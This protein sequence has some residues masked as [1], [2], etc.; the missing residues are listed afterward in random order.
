[1][2]TQFIMD[3]VKSQKAKFIIFPNPLNLLNDPTI[4]VK[5]GS[6]FYLKIFII[7]KLV[8][9]PRSLVFRC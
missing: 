8:E 7:C 3:I 2:F 9:I 4:R 6:T 1:M 5:E